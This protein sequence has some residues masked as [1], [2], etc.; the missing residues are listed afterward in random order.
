MKV[1]VALIAPDF[2]GKYQEEA[3]E[4]SLRLAEK[5]WVE[6]DTGEVIEFNDKWAMGFVIWDN[7]LKKYPEFVDC[8]YM[9][10]TCSY[11]EEHMV[12]SKY[13]NLNILTFRY[14]KPHGGLVYKSVEAFQY[15]E[16]CYPYEF[17]YYVR[18]NCNC[19]INMKRLIAATETLPTH[20]V[21]TTPL[22]EGI[23]ILG[24]FVL[25]SRDLAL[26]LRMTR[27]L[28]ETK[29]ADDYIMMLQV[30]EMGV[31]GYGWVGGAYESCHNHI[32]INLDPVSHYNKYGIIGSEQ[33]PT[34][35]LLKTLDKLPETVFMYRFRNLKD[36]KYSELYHHLLSRFL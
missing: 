20:N 17:K 2:N 9:I 24:W 10:R 30:R 3:F 21:Y 11:Q 32:G 29:N 35:E 33:Q 36:Y 7:I 13:G 18:G 27:E 6:G 26:K 1:G 16:K 28:R 12:A 15:M 5:A 14:T 31:E 22:W 19:M 25:F 4:R 34:S 8:V 23:Y